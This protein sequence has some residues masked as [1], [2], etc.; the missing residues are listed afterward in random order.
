MTSFKPSFL[1]IFLVSIFAISACGGGSSDTNQSEKSDISSDTNTI[2]NIDPVITLNGSSTLEIPKDARYTDAGATATDNRDGNITS[3]IIVTGDIVVT[4]SAPGTTFTII[5]NVFDLAGNAAIEVT[6]TVSIITNTQQ[7]PILSETDKQNYLYQINKAR[8]ETRT[9]T[10]TGTFPAVSPVT[11]SDKLYKAAYEH[12]QDMTESNTF[13]HDGSGTVSDWS[14]YALDKQSS[15][16]DRVENYNYA[17][18]LISENIS[19]GTD[20][21]TPEE[22]MESWLNSPDHC[23]N[24]MNPNVTEVGMAL[25]I[26]TDTRYTHYWTQN[27]GTPR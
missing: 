15:L 18:T 19:A 9:C 16:R 2:D 22:A 12:S 27:F 23:H 20:W 26:N 14:G 11:W 4:S 21:D 3:K 8:A 13:S 7:I 5:Y 6:R 1:L 17:W 10:N 25:S 24:I